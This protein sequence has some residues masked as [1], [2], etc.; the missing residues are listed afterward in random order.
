MASLPAGIVSDLGEAGSSGTGGESPPGSTETMTYVYGRRQTA[1]EQINNTTGTVDYLHHDQAGSTRLLTGSTGTVTGKCSYSAYGT[2]TCEGTA[3]T[4]LGYD[5]QYTS[6]DTGLIYL[7]ARV[8]D[9]ATA[10]FLT[11]DPV[12]SL[13]REPYVYAVDNPVNLGDPTGYEA[14]PFP[15]GG[16]GGEAAGGAALCGDPVTAAICAGAAGYG[17]YKAGESIYNAWAGSEGGDEG[18]AELKRKEAERE[19]ECGEIPRGAIDAE[20]ALKK[21]ARET[22][23][24]RGELG[25]ALEE[26]KQA[27]GV[28]P[29]GNTKVDPGTGDIFD[30]ETGEHIGN[31]FR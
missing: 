21:I 17:A 31:V 4:P 11:V 18:E 30:E 9:P 19:S 27:S 26:A 1:I 8:Y 15:I 6:S 25:K 5:G 7:R 16:A 3:T 13:T 20:A 28:P 23:I 24:P 10:Q 29:N 12:A 2:P 22:G 14:I